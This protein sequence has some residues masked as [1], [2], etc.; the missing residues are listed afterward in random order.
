VVGV[1]GATR[2]LADGELVLVDADRGL[3]I[4]LA[5]SS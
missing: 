4:K 2:R 3:V 1:P 5:G